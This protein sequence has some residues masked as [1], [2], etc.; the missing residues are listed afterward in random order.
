LPPFS[1]GSFNSGDG[2]IQREQFPDVTSSAARTR[3]RPERLWPGR[4]P[5][6][7]S[8]KALWRRAL[9]VYASPRLL[10]VTGVSRKDSIYPERRSRPPDPRPPQVKAAKLAK[11]GSLNRK[12]LPNNCTW[13]EC[14]EPDRTWIAGT[15]PGWRFSVGRCRELRFGGPAG[16]V[17]AL[18]T[19]EHAE[20]GAIPFDRIGRAPNQ[21]RIA[22][23]PG[24][25]DRSNEF[26]IFDDERTP[27]HCP[28]RDHIPRPHS[29]AE[30]A[31]N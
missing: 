9:A 2:G 29:I 28:A 4:A 18:V 6:L 15:G 5:K 25:A 17:S 19:L 23:A 13:Q 12:L 11:R 3:G 24:T 8:R 20:L 30:S 22:A 14:H 27:F 1:L 31:R 21:M 10:S 16:L 7:P 26:L